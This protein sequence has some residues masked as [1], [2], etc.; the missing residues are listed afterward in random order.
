[1]TAAANALACNLD[2]DELALWSSV[3]D[4][5]GDTLADNISLA[6]HRWE[7]AVLKQPAS[8]GKA[9]YPFRLLKLFLS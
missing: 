2:D 9:L 5:L 8:L 7:S 1:M 6:Y 3:L 4:Q